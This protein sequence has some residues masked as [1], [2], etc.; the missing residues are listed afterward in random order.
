MFTISEQCADIQKKLVELMD[1]CT[2]EPLSTA[3]MKAVSRLQE[4]S[5]ALRDTAF[6]SYCDN[7][8]YMHNG[9]LT[10]KTAIVHETGKSFASIKKSLVR[11]QLAARYEQIGQTLARNAITTDHI[12]LLGTISHDKYA[13]Y[14]ERDV[15]LL[16]KNAE[17]IDARHFTYLVRHWKNM[18]NALLDEPT[19]EY[20]DCEKRNLF[21]GETMHGHWTFHG[22][23]DSIAGMIIDKAL[24]DIIEKIWNSS[25]DHERENVS[26][27]QRRADALAF[28]ARGYVS[29]E[30]D[31]KDD[32]DA[33][34]R[35][36]HNAPITSDIVIDI[37]AIA[38]SENTHEFLTRALDRKTPLTSAHSSQAI[39]QI[40]C[41]SHVSFPIKQ[42]DGS[43]NLGR[44]VRI[45]PARMKRQLALAHSTCFVP[46]CQVPANWCDAHH[47]HHWIDGGETSIENL[48]LLCQRHHT[49]IHN[50]KQ[51]EKH[52]S[53]SLHFA[54]T[55]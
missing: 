15:D 55:G 53:Q 33:T 12:D 19:D 27:A 28:L 38:C 23:F 4:F 7:G 39:K 48:A 26:H 51:F 2:T 24:D 25:D 32:S 20:H 35:Y 36:S 18:V 8:M 13:P 11:G 47:L 17:R 10:G 41:D 16:V 29:N 43:Y 31:A 37:D 52:V 50:D 6:A 49:M 34:H 1:C 22:E 14:F 54:D 44:R 3:E 46:G 30:Y 9:Y 42:T 5:C 40:L 21:L 45:A